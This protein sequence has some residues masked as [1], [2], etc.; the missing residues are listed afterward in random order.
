LNRAFLL[1]PLALALASSAQADRRPMAPERPGGPSRMAYANPSAGIAADIAFAR[2]AQQKGRWPA[3]RATAAPDA[4]MFVPQMVLAQAW[5]KKAPARSPA[6]AWQPHAAWASCDGSVIVTSGAW[7]SGKAVGW[8]TTVWQRQ[9]DGA[10]K[11]VFD[12]GDAAAESP[13]APEMIEGRVAQCPQRRAGAPANAV[14]P[15]PPRPRKPAKTPPVVF[16]PAHKE[17][18]SNDGSLIWQVT[19][20]PSGAHR[21]IAG[22]LVDGQI[23]PFRD[24]KIAVGGK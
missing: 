7:Q 1:A 10:Y 13:K 6:L 9:A 11:W 23:E 18:R 16:D 12:H 4:V 2:L 14:A 21:F 15:P 24:E 22:M 19:A 8:Y 5:L 3:F 20:E 17:G